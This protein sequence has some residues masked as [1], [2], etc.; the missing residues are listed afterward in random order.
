MEPPTRPDTDRY[1]VGLAVDPE[2]RDLASVARRMP[3]W[4]VDTPFNRPLAESHWRDHHNHTHLD[5]VT[6]FTVVAGDLPE[7]WCANV[8]RDIDLHHGQHSHN[9]PYS[10]VEVFGVKLTDRLRNA[11]AEFGFTTFDERGDGFRAIAG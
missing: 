10:A 5:G 3:L 9:P 6:L 11:F 8:L 1:V 2:F 4:V 7:E